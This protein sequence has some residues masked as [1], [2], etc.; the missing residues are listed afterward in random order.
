MLGE[1]HLLPKVASAQYENTRNVQTHVNLPFPGLVT[2]RVLG[3]FLHRS[4]FFLTRKDL[5]ILGLDYGVD[6]WLF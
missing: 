3:G 5:G 2:I 1:M 6:H 4:V